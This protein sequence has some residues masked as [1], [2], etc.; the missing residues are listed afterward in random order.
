MRTERYSTRRPRRR[1]GIPADAPTRTTTSAR[2]PRRL[3]PVSRWPQ[4]K[5]C[6]LKGSPR[7]RN[8]RAAGRL[9]SRL[10]PTSKLSTPRASSTAARSRPT[11]QPGSATG[12]PE[13]PKA[14]GSR[15][16]RLPARRLWFRRRRPLGPQSELC[17]MSS[18]TSMPPMSSLQASPKAGVAD[19]E[20]TK[21]STWSLPTPSSTCTGHKSLSAGAGPTT[22]R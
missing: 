22:L 1:L 8:P 9:S 4:L 13:S 16:L 21:K 7:P 17:M 15:R 12:S 3:P 20:S 14:K 11:T 6:R 2:A 18:P 5:T 10:S 19:A